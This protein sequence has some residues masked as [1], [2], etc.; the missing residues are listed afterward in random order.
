LADLRGSVSSA[1]RVLGKLLQPYS[2]IASDASTSDRRQ[3]IKESKHEQAF[4]PGCR[5]DRLRRRFRNCSAGCGEGS[6]R[7][8]RRRSPWLPGMMRM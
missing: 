4:E 7:A 3:Q 6:V 1:V 2:P 5:S 8:T